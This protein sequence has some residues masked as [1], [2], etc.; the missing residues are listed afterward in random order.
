M[1]QTSLSPS[2]ACIIIASHISNP[3]RITH[4]IECLTSLVYQTLPIAIYL[5]ISFETQELQHEFSVI[6]SENQHLCTD[7]LFIVIR[8]KKT[9]QM[10]HMNLLLPHILEHKREWVMFCDDDDTYNSQRVYTILQTIVNAID[11]VSRMPGNIL[12]GVYESNIH[13]DHRE[14]RHEYWCYCVHISMLTR[15]MGTISQYE[16]VLDNTCCDVL[17]GEYL[18]RAHPDLVYGIINTPLYNYRVE[19]NSDSITGTIQRLNK[20][21][22]KPRLITETN[23]EECARELSEYLDTEIDIYLHDF[24]LRTLVGM[25]FESILRNEFLDEYVIWDLVD[26]KH[27]ERITS[28]HERLRDICNMIYDVKL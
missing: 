13:K 27:R 4:L 2:S 16:D 12:A 14:Q 24:Y 6:F 5:S 19:N 25:D 1:S 17:F 23:H 7:L 8:D 22:R 21:I 3:K 20:T 10:R 18:R 11:T 15:F 9:P 28:Y 26:K